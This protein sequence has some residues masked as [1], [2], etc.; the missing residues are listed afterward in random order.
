MVEAGQRFDEHVHTLIPELI[1]TSRE[2]VK[3]VFRVEIVMSVE[4]A[5][6]K[7]VYLLLGLL[8]Q[9]LELVDGR[10][11]GHV[12]TIGQHTVG[13]ALEQVLALEGRDMRYGG[14][15][16]TAMSSS[17]LDA[18]PMVDT[19]LSCLRI[20]I[21]PLQVVVEIDGASAKVSAQEGC[22]GREDGRDVY[23]P[24]LA[25]RKTNTSKPF[26]EMCDHS[27]LLLV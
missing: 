20:Y 18:I 26:V 5:A 23:A 14:E 13:F 8:M 25:K 21:K 16:V 7:I 3:R 24:P 15:N 4:V 27:F 9:V 11:L 6:H 17:A 2:E 10:E 22:V 1:S 19:T 12:Q